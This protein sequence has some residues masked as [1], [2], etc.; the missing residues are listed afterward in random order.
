V[1][2][3]AIVGAAGHIAIALI[4]VLPLSPVAAAQDCQYLALDPGSGKFRAG[5]L[6]IDL[7]EAD[8]AK[9][10]TAWQGPI[11]LAR[12][13]GTSCSVDPAVS[14]VEGPIYLDGQHLLVTTYSGSNRVLFAV[15]AATC[16]VLW[17]SQPFAGPVQL[18]AGT[19][20]TGDRSVSLGAACLPL[21][22]AG[23]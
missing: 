19:L 3:A 17:R 14:I 11:T 7:G 2:P 12:P 8:N 9:Q 13:G 20:H 10:P 23:R 4:A 5:D 15:D 22:S 6:S 1:T 18:D 21:S 16:T